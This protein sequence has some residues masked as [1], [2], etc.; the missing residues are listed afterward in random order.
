M[1]ELRQ[2]FLL[3]LTATIWG[4]GFIGQKLGMNYVSPYTFAFM[5][6]FIGALFLVPFIYFI[7]RKAKRKNKPLRFTKGKFLIGSLACGFFLILSESLQQFG[8]VTTDVN[9]TSFLTSLYMIFT[10]I[11]GVFLGQKLEFKVIVAVILSTFGL[12]LFCMKGDFSLEQGDLL[13]LLCALGFSLHILVIAYF[14]KFIDGVILSCGQ[15]FCASLLGLIMMLLDGVPDVSNLTLA[16]P[17]ILYCGIMVLLLN[18][19]MSSRE[20]LG[21]SL[22]FIAIILT[23]ISF[24]SFKKLRGNDNDNDND[25]NTV[26]PKKIEKNID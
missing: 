6:T 4:S 14:V 15:F 11:I 22:M 13:V 3:F 25:N 9:K 5:R 17:A 16:I 24:S 10:P 20:I 19:T 21:A 8:L 2:Y 12:Y 23:Q 7:I 18:E 1:F 26:P